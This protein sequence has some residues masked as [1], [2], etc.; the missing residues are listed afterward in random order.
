MIRT[1][2]ATTIIVALA[3]ALLPAHRGAEPTLACTGGFTLE[4]AATYDGVLIAL[5]DVVSAGDAVNRAPTL[6]PTVTSTP[7]PDGTPPS[8]PVVEREPFPTPKGFTLEGYGATVR[9]VETLAGT[10]PGAVFEVDARTRAGIEQELLQYEAGLISSCEPGAFSFRFTAG[11]RYLVFLNDDQGSGFNTLFRL[12]VL[13]NEVLLAGSDVPGDESMALYM[14]ADLYH[15]FF[16]GEPGEVVDASDYASI[17]TDRIPLAS[18]LAAVAYVR[19]EGNITPPITG[20][21]GLRA[22]R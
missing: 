19:G 13:G 21:A 3:V 2:T 15:R 4:V 20:S 5:V 18:V 9:V 12:P 10:A 1:V 7:A 14:T 22:S 16:E 8:P 17:Q 6:T 11:V